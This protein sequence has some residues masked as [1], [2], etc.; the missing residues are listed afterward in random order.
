MEEDVF[1][2]FMYEGCITLVLE[3]NHADF[4]TATDVAE[5]IHRLYSRAGDNFVQAKDATNIV[6][7]VPEEY[8]A[9][10]V[11]FV[12]AILSDTEVYSPEPEAR[13]VINQRTGSDCMCRRPCV[14]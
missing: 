14:K 2:Q 3:K 4:Q 12:A 5:S 9:D 11:E 1:T 6:I 7:R 13:V 8:Q 10:P